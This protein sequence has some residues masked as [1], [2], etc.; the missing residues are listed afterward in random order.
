[1]YHN[2]KYIRGL[3]FKTLMR[4]IRVFARLLLKTPPL[5][6]MPPISFDFFFCRRR[7][8]WRRCQAVS[9]FALALI[10]ACA[11]C[12]RCFLPTRLV[13]RPLV[14]FAWLLGRGAGYLLLATSLPHLRRDHRHGHRELPRQVR[15]VCVLALWWKACGCVVYLCVCVC[16]CVCVSVCVFC[17]LTSI[18]RV[19]RLTNEPTMLV[20][21]GKKVVC[22]CIECL[23]DVHDATGRSYRFRGVDRCAATA[24]HQTKGAGGDE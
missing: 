7:R 12:R 13:D 21:A 24:R 4:V 6:S 18:D 5:L 14:F 8:R 1:M 3:Q 22:V 11:V 10:F 20:V 16:V 23:C 9:A 15:Q 19:T 2:L 17:F